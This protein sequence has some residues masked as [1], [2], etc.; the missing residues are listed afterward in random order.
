MSSQRHPQLLQHHQLRMVNNHKRQFTESLFASKQDVLGTETSAGKRQ[1]RQSTYV[2]TLLDTEPTYSISHMN[3]SLFTNPGGMEGWGGWLIAESLPTSWVPA[4]QRLTYQSPSRQGWMP[5]SN[6]WVQK[7]K[8][9]SKFDCVILSH[10][11]VNRS[12][13]CWEYTNFPRA[14]KSSYF[15]PTF[16]CPQLVFEFPNLSWLSSFTKKSCQPCGTNNIE[17]VLHLG[18]FPCRRRS[19]V[20]NV[21]SAAVPDAK[22]D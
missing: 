8:N 4:G 20:P 14:D 15:H 2:A 9:V 22:P 13:N 21:D 7:R 16:G 3:Y 5:T 10:G 19:S 17:D 12:C 18:R 6:Q 11:Q 1:F